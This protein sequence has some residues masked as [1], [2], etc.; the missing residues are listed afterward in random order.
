[1]TSRVYLY[2]EVPEQ[3]PLPW[4]FS[5]SPQDLTQP[6]GE[7]PRGGSVV[8]IAVDCGAHLYNPEV[9][10]TILCGIPRVG[11]NAGSLTVTVRSWLLSLNKRGRGV[12]GQPPAEPARSQSGC[13]SRGQALADGRDHTQDALLGA[14]GHRLQ[15]G[16]GKEPGRRGIWHPRGAGCTEGRLPQRGG[17]SKP[18]EIPSDFPGTGQERERGADAAA[19]ELPPRPP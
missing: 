4:C 11:V 6:L 7:S 10:S 17:S 8:M 14:R 12:S 2:L 9:Y 15:W 5:S 13:L 18:L 19:G 3:H 16:F 1:M